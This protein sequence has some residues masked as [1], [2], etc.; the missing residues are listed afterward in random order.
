M[1]HLLVKEICTSLREHPEDWTL[2]KHRIKHIETHVALWVASGRC[3]VVLNHPCKIKFSIWNKIRIWR[4]F[5]Y[6][7]KNT[8]LARIGT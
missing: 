3:F 7:C 6:W 4:A 2:N 5:K 8:T 1:K